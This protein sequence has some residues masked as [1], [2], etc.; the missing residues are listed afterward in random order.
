MTTTQIKQKRCPYCEGQ[1]YFQLILG[2]TETCQ[3]CKGTGKKP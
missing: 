1:G 2:G 3:C